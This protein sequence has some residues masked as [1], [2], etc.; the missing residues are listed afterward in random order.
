MSTNKPQLELIKG[1]WYTIRLTDGHW[2]TGEFKGIR[3]TNWLHT[4]NVKRY[5]FR[6][7]AT[8]RDVE[9]KSTVRI[10]PYKPTRT[11]HNNTKYTMDEI[12]TF[13]KYGGFLNEWRERFVE[14]FKHPDDPEGRVL[15]IGAN[16]RTDTFWLCDEDMESYAG[17]IKHNDW[18]PYTYK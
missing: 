6:N 3:E 15:T 16:Y 18:R 7:V 17:R 8:G 5:M 10:R 2:T 12:R 13:H 9:L 1:R 14:V 4:R 11:V